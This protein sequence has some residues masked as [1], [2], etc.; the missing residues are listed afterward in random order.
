[1]RVRRCPTQGPGACE[2][3]PG[4]WALGVL[5]LCAQGPVSRGAIPGSP[6]SYLRGLA[7]NSK[8][9]LALGFSSVKW[10]K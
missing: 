3:P 7:Q 2:M 6:T 1:M 4:A 10:R 9:I 8:R 5:R